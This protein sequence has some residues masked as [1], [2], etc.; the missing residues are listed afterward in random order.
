MHDLIE[1]FLSYKLHN[2]GRAQ[3]T[4]ELY[5]FALGR[6][7]EFLD[8]KD[9]LVVTQ[10][11]L[12]AYAGVWLFKKG[13]QPVNRRYHITA[14]R[15]FYS[16]LHRSR[17]IGGN[18][19]A[20]V[21][22]PKIPHSTPRSLALNNLQLIMAQPDMNTFE[23][24]RDATMLALLADCGLRV[25]GLVSLNESNVVHDAHDGQPCVC[26]RLLEKGRERIIPV[27]PVADL[28]LRIYLE[29]PELKEIDR[30][31]KSG[32]RVLFVTLRNRRHPA[33]EYR[34]E[35]RR[36]SARTVNDMI[37]KYGERAGIPRDQLHA[38]A[39]RHLYGTE[40]A[41]EEVDLL[42]RQRL[43]GHADPKTT[44]IYT[45]L[46]LRKLTK[47]ARR[48]SPLSKITTPVSEVLQRLSPKPSSDPSPGTPR[49]G[50]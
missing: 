11:E 39:F 25:S 20:F 44:S 29:H 3:R 18:P 24:L 42:I 45:S 12:V 4:I 9:P 16:W 8:G 50:R 46:A 34:G 40:L 41:E 49:R 27:P 13:I 17:L 38:H 35:H 32:D 19:A 15:E 6:F 28:L 30:K 26:I 48:G 47:E 37:V 23:G 7:G 10:D 22:Y 31:L 43:M 33:G 14:V 1:R 5:R 2:Q 21:P 36:F